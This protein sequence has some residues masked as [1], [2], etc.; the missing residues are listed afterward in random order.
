[1]T[2]FFKY[3]LQLILENSTTIETLDKKRG[4]VMITD[5]L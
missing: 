1:M 4:E 2:V 3:H 5:V